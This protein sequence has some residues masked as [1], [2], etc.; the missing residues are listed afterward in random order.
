MGSS[1]IKWYLKPVSVVVAILIVGPF[2]LPL[3]WMS[4]AFKAWQKV[5]I[6][7]LLILAT[8]WLVQVSSAVYQQFL[9]QMQSLR[10]TM[11]R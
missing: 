7:L 10:D 1:S 3:V 6:S 2:A 4:P 11:K 5:A 8:I 9:A